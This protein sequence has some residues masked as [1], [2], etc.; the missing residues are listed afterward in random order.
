[1]LFAIKGFCRPVKSVVK[2]SFSN[3]LKIIAIEVMKECSLEQELDLVKKTWII[4]ILVQLGNE[5]CPA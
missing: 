3:I 1:M 2:L 5:S 4:Y